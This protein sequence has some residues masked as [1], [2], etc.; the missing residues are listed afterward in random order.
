MDMKMKFLGVLIVVLLSYYRPAGS[1][2]YA[3][4][5]D[6]DYPTDEDTDGDAYFKTIPAAI[7][8]SEKG[9][10]INVAAGTYGGKIVLNKNDLT[11][12][13]T[14]GASVTFINFTGVWC[15]YWSTGNGGVDIP[16][17]IGGVTV[18]GFTIVGGSSASDALISIGGN[19]NLI[20]N[21]IIIGDPLSSGQDIGIHIGDVDETSDQ[22]PSGN[23]IVRNEVYNHAGSG[24]FVGNW[25]GYSNVVSGNVVHDNVVGG[26]PGLNGNGIEADR[27]FGVSVTNNEVYN[28]EVAGIKVVRTVPNALIRILYN[29]ITANGTGILSEKWLSGA[30]A[31][32]DVSVRCNNIFGNTAG[33]SNTVGIT[34]DAGS[35]WWGDASGPYHPILNPGGTGDVVSDTVDFVPWGVA[36]DPCVSQ[37]AMWGYSAPSIDQICPLADYNI[38]KAE[39]MLGTVRKLL[40]NVQA[41]DLKPSK[42]EELLERAEKLLEKAKIFSQHSENCIAANILAIETQTLLEKA[43]TLLRT[44]LG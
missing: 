21:N 18:E 25:A 22:L 14:A 41:L 44:M 3:V 33:V 15:G 29:T 26:I 4:W 32:A 11:L 31:S 40:D 23:R 19:N 24:I 43:E 13:S 5:V 36:A 35:N 17:G 8:A 30:T 1:L 39:Y 7:A 20:C 38:Q 27:V 6:D 10:T 42:A 2:F 34:I 16:R 9:G 12:K 28:N 37:G